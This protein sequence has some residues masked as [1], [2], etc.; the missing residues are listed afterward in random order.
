MC[1]KEQ[2]T[3]QNK[4]KTGKSEKSKSKFGCDERKLEKNIRSTVHINSGRGFVPYPVTDTVTGFSLPKQ[5][6]V[7]QSRRN[8]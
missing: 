8:S 1:R 5:K 7:K 6:L 2:K 4:A 3:K